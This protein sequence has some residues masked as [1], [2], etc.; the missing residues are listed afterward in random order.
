MQNDSIEICFFFFLCNLNKF[1]LNLRHF[2]CKSLQWKILSAL[3]IE[4]A[5]ISFSVVN[6]SSA[7]DVNCPRNHQMLVTNQSIYY[8]TLDVGIQFDL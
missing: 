2:L 7:C 6:K 8:Y 5:K 3:R 4:S 1:Q